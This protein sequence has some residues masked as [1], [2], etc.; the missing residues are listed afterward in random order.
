MDKVS[1][2]FFPKEWTFLSVGISDWIKDTPDEP[3]SR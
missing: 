1:K 3:F 2:Y